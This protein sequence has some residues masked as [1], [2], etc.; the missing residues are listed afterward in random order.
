MRGL[1]WVRFTLWR[2]QKSSD[3]MIPVFQSL[4]LRI[5]C[6]TILTNAISG[7]KRGADTHIFT[8]RLAFFPSVGSANVVA[9][10]GTLASVAI[11]SLTSAGLLA[12]DETSYFVQ[13]IQPIL[14]RHCYECHSHGS[15]TMEGGLV[16][17]WRSGW[18]TGGDRGPAIV[19]G[20]AEGSLLLRAVRHSDPDLQMP[21]EKIS[22][23]E[24]AKLELW[25]TR[26]AADP[27]A[28]Q[29][30]SM[31]LESP[32]WSWEP[33]RSPDPPLPAT[34]SS[35]ANPIDAW[36]S[37]SLS[38]HGLEPQPIAERRHLLRRLW[39]D[40]LGLHPT[41][42]EVEAFERDT[43]P[44]AWEKRVEECLSRPQYAERWARHWLDTVHY[45]DSHG[46]EHDVFRPHAWPYRDYVIRA[47]EEDLPYAEF[48]KSQLAADVFYPQDPTAQAALGFLG[49]G[50]YD[51]SAAA[52]A[53]MSFEYLDRDDLVTQVCG[54]LLSTTANCARCHAHK[55]DPIPQQDYF[56]LQAV[57]AGVLKGEIRYDSDPE[58]AAD[59][60]RW[61]RIVT[62]AEAGDAPW[63]QSAE[64]DAVL[65]QWRAAKPT[66]WIPL[67]YDTFYSTGGAKL[68]RLEDGSVLATGPN[69][70]QERVVV[71]ATTELAT[72][73]AFRLDVLTDASLPQGGPGR[74][75]NGN[76]HLNEISFQ[77]FSPQSTTPVSL[78]IT[79]ASADF[80]QEGWT[81]QHAI[82]G[83]PQSAWGIFPFV[84]Q[85]H[86][87]I[88]VLAQPLVVDPNGKIVVGLQQTHGGSHVSGRFLLSVCEGD[89]NQAIALS[90]DVALIERTPAEE[91]TI[92][93]EQRLRA[94]VVAKFAQQ[95]LNSLPEPGRL[96]AAGKDVE[97]ERG[98]L[99]LP[100]PRMIH[101]LT[102][103]D[104]EKPR[105]MAMPG[106][107]SALK[108]AS[109]S[110]DVDPN[111]KESARRAALAEW[112][113]HP[114]NPLA[115]RSIANRV[116]Y[117][118]FGQGLSNTLNDFGRMGELPSHPEL[119]DWLACELR[120]TGS[121]KHLHR[122]IC[123]SE[124]YRRCCR[125]TPESQQQDPENRLLGR[126]TRRRL[127]AESFRDSVLV[128]SG[129]LDL[130][131]GGPGVK[132]FRES[133][134]P[135]VT[136]KLHYDDF[137]LESPEANR[138]SIYRVVWRGIPDPLFEAL[139]FPDL[140]LLAPQ[141]HRSS[142]PLQ[143][144]TLLNHRFVLHHAQVWASNLGLESAPSPSSETSDDSLRQAVRQ[145]W[146]RQASESEVVALRELAKE[147]GMAAVCRLLINSNE[148]LYVD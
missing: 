80:S 68:E 145:V 41:V 30:L 78:A 45:A 63:L 92:E 38:A 139:D 86:H 101:V 73:T 121:L 98:R 106:A 111:A 108:H 21:A 32:W 79:T 124:A 59:R 42:A 69:P 6:L 103:G 123:T 34:S 115:W 125:L 94:E 83:N 54:S 105:D 127:D 61:Q 99:Q 76:L 3:M 77:Y 141:R 75:P 20:D 1:R 136:P 47:F 129:R 134:G 90:H 65:S 16:L 4:P 66:R 35:S 95:R 39:I 144:L 50:P 131:R 31:N 37:K 87:G 28:A 104:L 107:L 7:L 19:P 142:S 126:W 64:A 128:L 89:A 49:A 17:D 116:W 113:V 29:P 135:Q 122:L 26:G 5:V 12:D 120:D 109:A 15:G 2:I 110:F 23:A 140:G 146:L 44:D 18:A 36:V 96:Y 52:T 82:D 137:D 22:D 85:P 97:N 133:P 117:Y 60:Q 14:E 53:P 71:T 46:F 91:R 100:Q 132:Y 9:N 33:L 119:L 27:R 13:E 10:V 74:A 93:Q 55:F 43:A 57:F 130:S 118:H 40:L 48:I 70:E 114:E 88:F 143:S 56:A 67:N 72:V 8:L 58:V 112:I 81:I 62:L 11:L 51:Q 24:I 102:R 25:V 147:H 148:F 138:R 84:G